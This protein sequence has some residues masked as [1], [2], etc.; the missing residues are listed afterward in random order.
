MNTFIGRNFNA[1]SFLV[2]KAQSIGVAIICTAGEALT[3]S[4]HE[5]D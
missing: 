3:A 1:L 2:K 5:S 4:V